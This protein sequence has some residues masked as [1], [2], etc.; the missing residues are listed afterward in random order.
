MRVV[1]CFIEHDGK[2]LI[3]HRLPNKSQGDKWGIPA[4]KVDE[5]E[6]DRQTVIR[7]IMEE[8]QIDIS[9][10]D[11]KFVCEMV[12]ILPDKT[13]YF[14]AFRVIFDNEPKVIINPNEHQDFKWVTPKEFYEMPNTMTGIKVLLEKVGYV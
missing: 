10:K 7:E 8:T 12:D 13:V 11:I 3:L 9:N 14:Q 4:G 1:G 6:N 2:I 5:G